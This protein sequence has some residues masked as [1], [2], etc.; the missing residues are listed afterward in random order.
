LRS[1]RFAVGSGRARPSAQNRY[2]LDRELP[3]PV[4][5]PPTAPDQVVAIEIE[6][7]NARHPSG[8][9]HDGGGKVNRF[10]KED[11][12]ALSTD[13]PGI[14]VGMSGLGV[15]ASMRQHREAAEHDAYP[16]LTRRDS[17]SDR[18]RNPLI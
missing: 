12:R 9:W 7:G 15:L 14:G 18:S 3:S 2:G 1:S 10:A 5:S 4:G 17:D 11:G 16:V 8:P 6:P 13:G